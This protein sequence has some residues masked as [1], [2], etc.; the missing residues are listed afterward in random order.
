ML[1]YII[2]HH[3]PMLQIAHFHRKDTKNKIN[4][5]KTARLFIKFSQ[6]SGFDA[7]LLVFF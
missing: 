6:I 5:Q 4:R 1:Y 3:L 7:I 2:K